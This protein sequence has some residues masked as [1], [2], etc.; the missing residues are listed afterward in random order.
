MNFPYGEIATDLPANYAPPEMWPEFGTVAHP[1][2]V[3]A[4]EEVGEDP[5]GIR[6]S[7]WPITFEEYWG[8]KEPD[9]EE[10][11]KGTLAR[12]RFVA[13]KRLAKGPVPKGWYPLSRRPGR[14]DGFYILNKNEDYQSDW[15]ETARRNFKKWKQQQETKGYRIESIEFKEFKEAFKKS[16][17]RKK[18]S[19]EYI[20]ILDRKRTTLACQGH[21]TLW[22]VRDPHSGAIVAGY[23]SWYSPTY[24]NSTREFPFMLPEVKKMHASVGLMDHWIA[25]ARTRGAELLVTTHFWYPGET[26]NWKGFSAFKAQFG[27]TFVA[28]PPTL[29]RFVRG[30]FF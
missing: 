2:T 9:L 28:Y 18:T 26:K 25:E 5:P 27:Y 20:D 15:S 11:K 12:N 13:W 10:S 4:R 29:W 21:Y 8:N 3:C 22:G 1:V 6:W 23:V 19:A 24:K 17:A 30:K 7:L 16:T 14:I